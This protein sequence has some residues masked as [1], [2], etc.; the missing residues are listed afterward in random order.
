MLGD[1]AL[2][3]KIKN[4][5]ND[6]FKGHPSVRMYTALVYANK[7]MYTEAVEELE[8]LRSEPQLRG[9]D[10]IEVL[11]EYAWL[12]AACDVGRIRDN[13]ASEETLNDSFEAGTGAQWKAWRARAANLAADEKWE[14]A[15]RAVDTATRQAPL[16]LADEL[17]RQRRAYEQRKGYWIERRK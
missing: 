11:T 2:A 1:R 3:E 17:S 14:E 15:I 4:V 9:A 12:K 10:R 7:S 5:L 8:K 16:L 6:K 13:K